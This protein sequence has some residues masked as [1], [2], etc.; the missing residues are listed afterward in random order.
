MPALL[1]VTRTCA[2]PLDELSWRASPPGGP[3]GQHANRSHTRV[4]VSFDVAASPSL[5]PRQRARLL[6][7]LGPTVRASAS[8]SRSQAANR[9]LA[10]E[11]LKGKLGAA[12]RQPP[13]RQPTAP[14]PAARERR[15][16]DKRRRSR[17]KSERRLPPEPD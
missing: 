3:G 15:L 6:D 7:R 4:V 2:I 13:A 11:R 14:S 8:E 10:L 17:R 9:D 1:Q 12:L 16:E 5:G